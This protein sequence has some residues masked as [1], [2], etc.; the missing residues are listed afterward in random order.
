MADWFVWCQ[1]PRHSHAAGP[2]IA[3]QRNVVEISESDE[4]AGVYDDRDDSPVVPT[5]RKRKA[6][7]RISD[8]E[9]EDVS[10]RQQAAK[11]VLDSEVS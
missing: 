8:S 5:R 9:E 3:H 4:E 6:A 11:D 7:T 1:G 10:G 2:S